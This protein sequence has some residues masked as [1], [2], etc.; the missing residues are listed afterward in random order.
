MPPHMRREEIC[1]RGRAPV[2]LRVSVDGEV[3]VENAY[4]PRGLFSDGMS[5][6]IEQWAVAAGAHEVLVEIGDSAD[7]SV[8]DHRD[9]RTVEFSGTSRRVV[10]FERIHGFQWL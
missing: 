5:I 8:W 3:L 1:A 10:I 9:S 2:R 6:A 7:P 4:P